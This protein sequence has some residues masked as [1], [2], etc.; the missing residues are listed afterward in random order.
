MT[1][2]LLAPAASATPAENPLQYTGSI[3]IGEGGYP[4]QATNPQGLAVNPANGSVTAAIHDGA[5]KG[6]YNYRY[7]AAT[8]SWVATAQGSIQPSA[9]PAGAAYLN[10]LVATID[11][12]DGLATGGSIASSPDGQ[13]ILQAN[14]LTKNGT[15]QYSMSTTMKPSFHNLGDPGAQGT[16]TDVAVTDDL[17]GFV[18]MPGWG[19]VEWIQHTP[20]GDRTHYLA[21]GEPGTTAPTAVAVNP[22]F[23]DLLYV[24]DA[25][26]GTLY[27]VDTATPVAPADG[28][29]HDEDGT[30]Y[31]TK[32]M[33]LGD[34]ASDSTTAAPT[35]I[36]LSP[37]GE[38][39]FVVN[40]GWDNVTVIDLDLSGSQGSWQ[41]SFTETV[42]GGGIQGGDPSGIAVD[43]N[44]GTV[45]V[46][47]SNH[48]TI[49]VL[50]AA[51]GVNFIG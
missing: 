15:A 37:N 39:V 22:Q 29:F 4:A 28:T 38:Y 27:E 2:V 47:N 21:V 1:G 50:K 30:Y 10:G 16:P 40:S 49:A 19:N 9:H 44:N 34:S 7:D 46:S 41:R 13:V 35:A 17:N 43:P 12:A 51:D 20:H 45:Y 25:Q 32:S 5:N 36:A 3:L 31:A 48:D 11:D 18:A 8:D 6:F 26:T 14:Q 24:A 33:T 23:Q 42:P